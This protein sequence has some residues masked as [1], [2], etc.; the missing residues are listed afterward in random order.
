VSGND[1][2][3]EERHGPHEILELGNFELENG[4]TIPN[5]SSRSKRTEF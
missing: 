1:Y 2:Y 3:T 4:I 5:A